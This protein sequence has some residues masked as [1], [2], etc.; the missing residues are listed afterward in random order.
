MKQIYKEYLIFIV[1]AVITI[2]LIICCVLLPISHMNNLLF[3]L[4][5]LIITYPLIII[6]IYKIVFILIDKIIKL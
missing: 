4:L 6:G 3:A 1:A 5:Y 2:I